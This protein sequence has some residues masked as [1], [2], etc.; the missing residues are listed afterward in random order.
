MLTVLFSNKKIVNIT[1]IRL[2]FK[3]QNYKIT[4]W[5]T[6]TTNRWN[7]FI[8]DAYL[9]RIYSYFSF[10]SE[11]FKKEILQRN[12]KDCTRSFASLELF[13]SP[14]QTGGGGLIILIFQT[15]FHLCSSIKIQI[16][17]WIYF[18]GNLLRILSLVHFTKSW[19]T[20][21]TKEINKLKAE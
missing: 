12:F 3:L 4:N 9:L 16:S 14:S 2:R 6:S 1:K 19:C 5:H 8:H 21:F 11:Y 7:C 17:M 15:L 18:L 10:R 13:E 20:I